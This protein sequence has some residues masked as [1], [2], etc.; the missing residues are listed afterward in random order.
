[1]CT[2]SQCLLTFVEYFHH[3][4]ARQIQ[5]KTTGF[6]SHLS[7][8]PHGTMFR[9]GIRCHH[10]ISSLFRRH[11]QGHGSS[12]AT[13]G[14][15]Y[16]HRIHFTPIPVKRINDSRLR[17]IQ[18][19][20]PRGCRLGTENTSLTVQVHDSRSLLPE[21]PHI[22]HI[23]RTSCSI[24]NRHAILT[25]LDLFKNCR[26]IFFHLIG[27]YSV[28]F[29]RISITGLK[30]VIHQLDIAFSTDTMNIVHI[31]YRQFSDRRQLMRTQIQY[32]IHA[33]LTKRNRI[34]RHDFINAL[35][36]VLHQQ[37][38]VGSRINTLQS[39]PSA[40]RIILI[41]L[42]QE[43]LDVFFR[44]GQGNIPI[45]SL[46]TNRTCHGRNE[47]PR[48]RVFLHRHFIRHHRAALHRV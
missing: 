8:H 23:K 30:M 31:H 3:A 4:T 33:D 41:T 9:C 17:I 22:T 26:I 11:L 21:Y 19:D 46:T 10:V 37:S 40:L 1:M 32:L 38:L 34:P 28:P 16:V 7:I 6:Q 48:P 45:T 5:I 20:K 47:F 12:I 29:Q 35:R 18:F 43:I 39:I 42:T 24:G 27:Q 15:Q 36:N 13:H 25:D 14:I 2:D 44:A